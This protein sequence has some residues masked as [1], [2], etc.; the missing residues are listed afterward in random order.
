MKQP[1]AGG[2]SGAGADGS[3]PVVFERQRSDNGPTIKGIASL[4]PAAIEIAFQTE[5]ET[6]RL[7]V[8][9]GVYA[10]DDTVDL[11]VTARS[12]AAAGREKQTTQAQ[13]PQVSSFS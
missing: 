2:V 1:I 9:S 11:E 12:A 10:T 3:L 4:D 13:Q 5:N 7:P 6:A 8:I